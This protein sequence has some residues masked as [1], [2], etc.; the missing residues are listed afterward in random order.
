MHG[1]RARAPHVGLTNGALVTD[2]Y[3]SR[4]KELYHSAAGPLGFRIQSDKATLDL[5]EVRVAI[6]PKGPE[7]PPPAPVL[8]AAPAP[9]APAAAAPASTP[10][11]IVLPGPSPQEKAQQEQIR[12]L[13]VD[14]LAA[15]TPDEAVR[16]NKQIL[17]LD[18]G[19]MPAAAPPG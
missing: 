2:Y 13:T 14:A 1:R 9:S 17:V 8:A 7:A 3:D 15:S 18:P 16:I 4:P 10:M 5:R 11:S 6:L 19:D 12:K